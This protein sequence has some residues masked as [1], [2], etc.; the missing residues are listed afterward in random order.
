MVGFR[1]TCKVCLLELG[2]IHGYGY[3]ISLF[4]VFLKINGCVMD[5]SRE[6]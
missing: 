5:K 2:W 1:C 4:F 3:L 6:K